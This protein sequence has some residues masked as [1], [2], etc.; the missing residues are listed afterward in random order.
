MICIHLIRSNSASASVAIERHVSCV[1]ESANVPECTFVVYT[2]SCHTPWG[3]ALNGLGEGP[4]LMAMNWNP[5]T[6]QS[7]CT[8]CLL[9]LHPAMRASKEACVYMYNSLQQGIRF[10]G[11]TIPECQ[12]KLPKAKVCVSIYTCACVC[13]HIYMYSYVYI[14]ISYNMYVIPYI[15]YIHM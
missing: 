1:C 13:M 4:E 7:T 8:M 12:E 15:C 11:L 3:K 9:C 10:R 5:R 14:Y 6:I 2:W